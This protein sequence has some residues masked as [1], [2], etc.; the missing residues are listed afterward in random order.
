VLFPACRLAGLVLSF[1]QERIV[2]NNQ[3]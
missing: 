1:A 3:E 2:N